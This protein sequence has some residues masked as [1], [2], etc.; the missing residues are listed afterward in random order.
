MTVERLNEIATR[1]NQIRIEYRMHEV[2]S[3]K[4]A[5]ELL[6]F[7]GELTSVDINYKY[8]WLN[9]SVLQDIHDVIDELLRK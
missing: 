1:T 5:E 8:F 6:D 4:L 9:Q 7:S 3:V 2:D